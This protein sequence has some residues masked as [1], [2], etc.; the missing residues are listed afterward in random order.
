MTE[1]TSARPGPA[2]QERARDV[3][4]DT[5][6][7]LT[8]LDSASRDATADH[9]FVLC[10]LTELT[11]Q[12][13]QL[14][15]AVFDLSGQAT[16]PAPPA[17]PTTP[18]RFDGM[19][20]TVREGQDFLIRRVQSAPVADGHIPRDVFALAITGRP[21]A[22][23]DGQINVRY[24]WAVRT[25]RLEGWALCDEDTPGAFPVTTLGGTP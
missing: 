1:Q 11:R 18:E 12:V 4:G 13:G 6:A 17:Q 8:V 15:I 2:P 19:P 5:L 22:P 24:T 25:D 14:A 21:D 9:H 7:S 10:M 20:C 3:L 16:A 23:P